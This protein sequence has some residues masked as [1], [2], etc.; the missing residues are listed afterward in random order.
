VAD[1]A[2]GEWGYGDT[3]EE[4]AAA[5]GDETF[6]GEERE[7]RWEGEGA[8][9]LCGDG[10]TH[11]VCD[12]SRTDGRGPELPDV[13]V[14]GWESGSCSLPNEGSYLRSFGDCWAIGGMNG[15]ARRWREVPGSGGRTS[16]VSRNS[17]GRHRD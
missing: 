8:A 11:Q 13:R 12:R 9:A 3:G 4:P 16:T 7:V 14:M 5:P 15:D 17:S 6:S 10:E 1:V 2:I